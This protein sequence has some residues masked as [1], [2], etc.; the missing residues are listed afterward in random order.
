MEAL[1]TEFVSSYEHAAEEAR[2]AR[3]PRRV[4]AIEA[5]GPLTIV[6]GIVWAIAQPYRIAF[7]HREGKGF[8]DYLAQAPLLVVVVG[9]FFALVVAPGLAADLESAADETQTVAE[10]DGAPR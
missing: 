1:S 3:R 4:L 6:G 10:A 5:I 9:L 8:Y 2:A 7:I